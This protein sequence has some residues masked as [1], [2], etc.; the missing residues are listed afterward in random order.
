MNQ[1]LDGMGVQE[2]SGIE[3]LAPDKNY[4]SSIMPDSFNTVFKSSDY[5]FGQRLQFTQQGIMS[6][7]KML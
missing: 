3:E 1:T 6:Q 5:G 4:G 2:V 7:I